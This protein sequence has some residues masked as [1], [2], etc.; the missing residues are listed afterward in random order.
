MG[1]MSTALLSQEMQEKRWKLAATG[2]YS[3]S[4][5][6][7]GLTFSILGPTLP[8]LAVQTQSSLTDISVLFV[9]RSLG[10]L[11]GSAGGGRMFDRFAGNRVVA[12]VMAAGVAPPASGAR[13]ALSNPKI[14]RSDRARLRRPSRDR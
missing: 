4:F 8:S 12:G 6:A 5:A 11:V 1:R 14:P 7:L 2:L 10:S 3:A 9:A 13:S